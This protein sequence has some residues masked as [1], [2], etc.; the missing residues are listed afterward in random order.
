MPLKKDSKKL[1][2]RKFDGKITA[3]GIKDPVKDVEVAASEE[4]APKIPQ[5][6]TIFL[7][8]V[9]FGRYA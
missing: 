2:A 3:R 6:L 7:L 1:I 4:E 5:W 8:F 9:L